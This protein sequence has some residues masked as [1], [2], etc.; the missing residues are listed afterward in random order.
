MVC[1]VCSV[2]MTEDR[3]V[4]D[5]DWLEEVIGEV[6]IMEAEWGCDGS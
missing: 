2:G 5:A 4:E 6:E 1:D 3:T